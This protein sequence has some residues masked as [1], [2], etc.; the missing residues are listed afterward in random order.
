MFA[1]AVY[2]ND[3]WFIYEAN[4]ENDEK[5]DLLKNG[6]EVNFNKPKRVTEVVKSDRW[7]KYGENI[8]MIEK[9]HFRPYL[10]SFLLEDWN[11]KHPKN[12]ITTLNIWYM[13]ELTLPDY[14]T[15]PIEKWEICSCNTP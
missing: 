5:I 1:P 6:K 2:K 9:A 8:L 13:H 11:I 3:G 12:Q 15:A 7:R 4:T 14:K 10:C